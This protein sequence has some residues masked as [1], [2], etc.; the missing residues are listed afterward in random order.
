[1]SFSW[2]AT[3]DPHPD[4]NMY[5]DA[6]SML[7]SRLLTNIE[8]AVLCILFCVALVGNLIVI[9]Y[10]LFSINKESRGICCNTRLGCKKIT[11]MSFYI[12]HLSIADCN[13]A[14]MSILPQ[15]FWRN[16]VFFLSSQIVCK[17]VT[18]FQVSRYKDIFGT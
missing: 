17:L 8:V 2:N 9:V 15:I 12:V 3:K 14:F 4:P 1:M 6:K 5:D 7:T 11:R 13:V 16:A 18:F 10:L